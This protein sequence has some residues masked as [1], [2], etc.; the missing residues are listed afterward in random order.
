MD[1]LRDSVARKTKL[2]KS[3]DQNIKTLKSEIRERDE[4]HRNIV[5][6]LRQ[7]QTWSERPLARFRSH[8]L[9]QQSKS[10]PTRIA[11]NLHELKRMRI[12]Y[13]IN[14]TTS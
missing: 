1:G 11:N 5:G 4:R 8:Q 7:N 14:F 3:R 12:Y 6:E 2:L 9:P 10:T 13:A